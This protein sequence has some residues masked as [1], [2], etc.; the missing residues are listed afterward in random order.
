MPIHVLR[1]RAL[2]AHCRRFADIASSAE[3]RRVLI[4]Q[5]REYEALANEL[6]AFDRR[7]QDEDRVEPAVRLLLAV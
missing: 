4:D 3:A 2:A 6:A 7:H 1:L 5:T